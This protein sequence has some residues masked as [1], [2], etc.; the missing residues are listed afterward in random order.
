MPPF[1][2]RPLA[3]LA[4]SACPLL[5]APLSAPLAA[6]AAPA[7]AAAAT[8][9]L[10]PAVARAVADTIAD[11]FVRAYVDADTGKLIA[12]RLRA[13][14]RAGAYDQVTNPLQFAGLLTKDLRAINGDKHL[15]VWYMPDD[16]L[17]IQL[18]PEGIRMR[19]TTPEPPPTAAELA[20]NRRRHF[21][22][23]RLDVLPGNVGYARITGF[24][25]NDAETRAMFTTVLRYL[26]PTDAIIFDFREMHGGSGE[27]SNFLLSHF[28]G[29][30]S[31]LS[32]RIRN[33]SA[34]ETI[35]RWTLADV[36]GPRRPDVPLFILTGPGTVSAGEDFTFVLH[37]LHRA[38]LVGETTA[39]AGHNN[40]VVRSGHGFVTSISFT[41]VMDPATGAEWERVGIRPDIAAPLARALDVAQLAALDTLGARAAQARNARG[42]RELGLIREVVAAQAAP[43]ALA[44]ATLKR[45]TGVYGD[46]VVTAGEGGL[47][48]HRGDFPAEDLVALGGDTF[49]LAAA[50]LNRLVFTRDARGTAALR[51]VRPNGESQTVARTG[52]APTRR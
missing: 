18:G 36:P 43:R 46:R 7:G 22:V 30:D 23:A 13:R 8:Q 32:L 4:L 9:P 17:A 41:R 11:Q 26:E 31:V 24:P 52:P 37:N 19:D 39:G 48:V 40:E 21:G 5:A 42:Q 35:D 51:I 29:P 38:T 1:L 25:G 34:A 44:A 12:A 50:P 16:E 28:T 10:T 27:L 15:A 20:M 45:Y 14:S 6:Q 2:R 49:A 3:A 33:R 47:R